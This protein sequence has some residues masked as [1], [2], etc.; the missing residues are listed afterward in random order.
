MK[1][2]GVYRNKNEAEDKKSEIKQQYPNCGHGDIVVGDSCWD[3]IDLVVR[4]AGECTL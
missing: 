3:E 4:P 1:I 2:V